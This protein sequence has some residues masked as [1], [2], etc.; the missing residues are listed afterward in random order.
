MPTNNHHPE[1][2]SP[3]PASP[4]WASSNG[5]DIEAISPA[6]GSKYSPNLYDWLRM[7]GNRHI[8]RAGHVYS[9]PD[10]IL[11]LGVPENGY[12]TGSRLIEILCRG[13]QAHIACWVGLKDLQLV[14][15]F[16]PAYMRDGRCAVDPSHSMGFLGDDTRWATSGETRECVWCG[17]ARQRLTR[18]TETI[19]RV[20]WRLDLS[21][22]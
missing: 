22:D 19:D 10:D 11:W 21:L 2:T 18:W 15:D 17:K 13:P 8:A 7:R 16:W 20:G 4:T 9:G 5:L 12:F 3:A 14:G 1:S 6:M